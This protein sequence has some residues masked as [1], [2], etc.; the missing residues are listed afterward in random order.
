MGWKLQRNIQIRRPFFANLRY[1]FIGL[2][3]FD[4]L[5]FDTLFT[6]VMLIEV[7]VVL[8]LFTF[9]ASSLFWI[10]GIVFFNTAAFDR[11][12]LHFSDAI[13]ADE[14]LLRNAWTFSLALRAV[15]SDV[16]IL[17]ETSEIFHAFVEAIQTQ[18][19]FFTDFPAL[20]ALYALSRYEIIVDFA[21]IIFLLLLIV[22][23]K[24]GILVFLKDIVVIVVEEQVYLMISP[25]W[26]S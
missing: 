25:A 4:S 22:V 17:L 26:A 5:L 1:A 16:L 24:T 14:Q 2:A 8:H 7:K 19:S 23:L 18:P 12:I 20:P 9:I 21:V 15:I 13:L 10:D 6:D 3:V 11:R